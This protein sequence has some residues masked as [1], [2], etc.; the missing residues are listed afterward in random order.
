MSYLSRY[1]GVLKFA[2][3]IDPAQLLTLEGI[4]GEDARNHPEWNE[5]LGVVDPERYVSFVDL[6]IEADRS[7][8]EVYSTADGASTGEDVTR[9]VNLVTA[10]MA[11]KFHGWH[12]RGHLDAVTE[13]GQPFFVKLDEEDGFARAVAAKVVE[14]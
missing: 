10:L 4:L 2:Q 8:L 13:E 6:T 3:P 11:K 9:L 7:G 14:A 1:S 5:T 12:L